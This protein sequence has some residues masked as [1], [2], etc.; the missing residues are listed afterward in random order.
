MKYPILIAGAL[1]LSATPAMA[2]SNQQDPRD[3]IGSILG[4]IFGERAPANSLDAQWS[5]GNMPLTNQRGTFEARVDTEV[6]S[7]ALTEATGARLKYDYYQLVQ[8]ETRYGAD[9][10]FTS[11]ERQELTDGYG[12][13]TQVL[14]DGSY[15]DGATAS[16]AAIA[17]GR[18]EFDQ[19]VDAAVAERR[20][21][22][23]AGTRLKSEYAALI[24]IETAYLRDGALSAEERADLDERLD[25]LDARVGDTGYATD[26]MTARQRLNAVASALPR[27]GLSSSAQAQV[28]VE[29]EDL[30]RLEQAYARLSTTS[31]ERAYLD[32]RIAQ[33]ETRVN[34]R[35]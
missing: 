28:L 13:L 14:A 25:A 21:R 12:R 34:L 20:I 27:S 22:R 7:G 30:S 33:L 11:Q 8:L 17:E 35:R 3:A 10:R 31:D 32:R 2:Q 26:R 15:A 23:T 6:R 19:R 5:A 4:A 1:A 16:G 29:H 9:R 18:A 24:D